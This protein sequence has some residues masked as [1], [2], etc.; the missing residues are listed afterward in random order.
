MGI[1]E[2]LQRL[3]ARIAPPHEVPPGMDLLLKLMNNARVELDGEGEPEPLTLQDRRTRSL[4]SRPARC[5]SLWRQ[6]AGRPTGCLRIRPTNS[7]RRSL[8][9]I[10]R[11]QESFCPGWRRRGPAHPKDW[12]HLDE[13]IE[14]TKGEIAKLD[15]EAALESRPKAGAKRGRRRYGS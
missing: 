14:H 12:P 3:E 1:N 5:A 9:S 6:P 2:R 13:W 15:E 8:P 10:G 7:R 11:P 4:R